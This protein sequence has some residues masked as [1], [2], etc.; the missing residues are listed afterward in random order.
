[1]HEHQNVWYWK[2]I[3]VTLKKRAYNETEVLYNHSLKKKN[4]N[5][6]RPLKKD[7]EQL[8]KRIEELKK[9][10]NQSLELELKGKNI[11]LVEKRVWPSHTES[12]KSDRERQILYDIAY[13]RNLKKNGTSELIYQ[14]EIE[15]Q[16]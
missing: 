14:T 2:Q 16:M 12:S 15:S 9:S 1:M 11:T 7:D 4:P 13:M 10:Y 3:D 6:Y 5:P 8:F